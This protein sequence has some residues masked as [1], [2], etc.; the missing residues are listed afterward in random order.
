MIKTTY[1]RK[2]LIEDL[3]TVS[4]GECMAIMAGG[5]QTGC[6]DTRVTAKSLHLI[7]KLK[8]EIL[9]LT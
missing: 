2:C 9:G 3:L 8:A 7:H 4:K 1:K 6:H 5:K